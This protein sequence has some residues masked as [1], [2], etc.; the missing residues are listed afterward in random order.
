[1]YLLLLESSKIYRYEITSKSAIEKGSSYKNAKRSLITAGNYPYGTEDNKI[2]VETK[3]YGHLHKTH[4]KS[5]DEIK[6]TTIT[7]IL[8]L[9]DEVNAYQNLEKCLHDVLVAG[10]IKY[11]RRKANFYTDSLKL[12]RVPKEWDIASII[13][14]GMGNNIRNSIYL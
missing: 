11:V 8:V 14:K 13:K 4:D 3:I 5:E 2:Y 12:R 9:V 6:D 10:F 1:M 7:K